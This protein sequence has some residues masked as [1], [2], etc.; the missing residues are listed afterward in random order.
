VEAGRPEY[1]VVEGVSVDRNDPYRKCPT[2]TQ[3]LVTAPDTTE[4][5]S[6]PVGIETCEIQVHP[7]GGSLW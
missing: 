3:L 5:S 7:L 2:Y 4:T 6:V 1:A